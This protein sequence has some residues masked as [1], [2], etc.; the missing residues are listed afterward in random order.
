MS[1]LSALAE[2]MKTSKSERKGERDA[3]VAANG[4]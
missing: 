2:G 4:D 1:G 3:S